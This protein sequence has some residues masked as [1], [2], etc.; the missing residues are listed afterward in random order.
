MPIDEDGRFDLP[1]GATVVTVQFEF[2]GGLG[3]RQ[4]PAVAWVVVPA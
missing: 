4:R 2:E 1:E 3:S